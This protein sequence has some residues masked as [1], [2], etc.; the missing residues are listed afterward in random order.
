MRFRKRPENGQPGPE[1]ELD[2]DTPPDEGEP[3]PVPDNQPDCEAAGGLWLN[4]RCIYD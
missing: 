2:E 1:P 4:G 3:V